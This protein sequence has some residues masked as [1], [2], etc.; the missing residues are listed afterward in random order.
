MKRKWTDRT[1]LEVHLFGMIELIKEARIKGDEE[2][3][4]RLIDC[5]FLVLEQ[6]FECI[7]VEQASNEPIRGGSAA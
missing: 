2:E 1:S 5:R 7:F 3:V 6:Y 4:D